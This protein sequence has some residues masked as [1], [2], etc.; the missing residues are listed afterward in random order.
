MSAIRFRYVGLGLVL[1]VGAAA[2][3]AGCSSNSD[4]SG[5][6]SGQQGTGG[7]SFGGS[8]SGGAPAGGNATGNG[9]AQTGN[10]GA[11]TGNG[12]AQAGSGGSNG[13]AAGGGTK[14]T[15]DGSTVTK[16]PDATNPPDLTF[17]AC[18]Q[19]KCTLA[20]CVPT[21]LIPAGT[22]PALLAKCADASQSCVPDAYIAAFGKFLPKTCTSLL[23]AEGRCIS[24]CIP[25][26]AQQYDQLP[27]DVC[28]DSEKCA[29]CFNPIDSTDTGACSQGCDTGP[30]DKTPKVFADCGSGRGKCVPKSLVPANLQTALPVDTCTGT[31]ELC[32]PTEKAKDL[33]YK[34]PSCAPVIAPAPPDPTQPAACVPQYIIDF[35]AKTNAFAG[36]LGQSTCAADEK[37]APC[38]NPLDGTN[39]GACD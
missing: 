15:L 30:V 6:P 3:V 36:L 4:A 39:T 32:A 27:K 8:G 34:F 9:G 7:F 1:S 2:V 37:C 25:Q 31:D 19:D 38:K 17:T 35:Q 16:C 12:G 20:H 29:P 14:Y 26:V 28:A 5:E 10:G 33:N 22:D 11:Q 24:S 13:G 23:G 21:A 18:A